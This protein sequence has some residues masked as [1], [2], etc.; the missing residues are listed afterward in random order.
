MDK[1]QFSNLKE[2]NIIRHKMSGHAYIIVYTLDWGYVAIRTITATSPRE[3]DLITTNKA[4]E[5]ITK[6]VDNE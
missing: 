4:M 5:N 2:G 6:E 3:W 1:S